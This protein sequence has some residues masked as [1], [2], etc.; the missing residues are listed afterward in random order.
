MCTD[1][2]AALGDSTGD[3]LGKILWRNDDLGAPKTMRP[4]PGGGAGRYALVALGA[5]READTRDG[6]FG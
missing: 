2:W 1:Q 3:T 4:A 6:I 5:G